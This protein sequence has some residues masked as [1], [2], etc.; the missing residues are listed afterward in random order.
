MLSAADIAPGFDRHDGPAPET[1]AEGPV[2]RCVL[3]GHTGPRESF[4]RFV[5][6][7]DGTVVPDIDGKLPGRGLWLTVSRAALD[8]AIAKNAFSKAARAKL[9]APGG[10]ADTVDR[11]LLR[12]ALDALSLAKRAGAV[13]AGF[14]KAKAL[15]DKGGAGLVVEALDASRA[16]RARLGGRDVETATGLTAEEMGASLG[17]EHAVHVALR[18][19]PMAARLK[20]DLTRLAA[21]RGAGDNKGGR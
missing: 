8:E 7:P 9:T 14:A 12:R 4:L 15:I 5:A 13:A 20:T 19:G 1:G 16:E 10:V 3:G 11:L 17:R 2:R 18:E 6:G 21:F